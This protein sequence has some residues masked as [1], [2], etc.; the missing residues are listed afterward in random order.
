MS[1]KATLIAE[2]R[3][4]LARSFAAGER[5]A[6]GGQAGHKSAPGQTA[7][8]VLRGGRRKKTY[9]TSANALPHHSGNH[10]IMV[11]GETYLERHERVGD[12]QLHLAVVS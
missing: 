1:R 11:G 10:D 9:K 3:P 8:G 7:G 2:G 6:S 5:W 12:G 4:P